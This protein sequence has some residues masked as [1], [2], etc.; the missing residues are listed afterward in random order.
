M[1]C[2]RN[3]RYYLLFRGQDAGP[4]CTPTHS[5]SVPHADGAL[6]ADTLFYRPRLLNTSCAVMFVIVTRATK[7]RDAVQAI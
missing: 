2:P 1:S 3:S 4:H 6:D 5:S 7:T